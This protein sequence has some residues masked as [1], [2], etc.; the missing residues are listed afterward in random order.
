VRRLPLILLVPVLVVALG[1]CTR[2]AV[3]GGGEARQPA[4]TT[5]TTTTTATTMAASGGVLTRDG[6]VEGGKS[7]RLRLQVERVERYRAYALLRFA[8]TNPTQQAAFTLDGFATSRAGTDMGGFGV[9]D[10]VGRKIYYSLHERNEVGPAVGSRSPVNFKPGVRY[11]ASV[12]YPPIPP[13]VK[14][15]TVIPPGSFGPMTGVPVI[16]GG[17][18]PQLPSTES[19]DSPQPGQTVTL[20]ATL[21]GSNAWS[22]VDDLYSL[23]DGSAG[24]SN[25]SSGSSEVV[26][27]R[28]D[29]LFKFNSA[30]LTST[31]K[32]VI[33]QIADDMA[34]RAD[35]ARTVG[36]TGHTDGKGTDAFNQTLSVHRAQTVRDE[37][38]RRLATRGFRFQAAGK[39]ERQPIA[40]ETKADG[41]DNPQGR[42]RNRRVEIAYHVKT[43]ADAT[44]TT[45]SSPALGPNIGPPA[46]FRAD[47][48]PVVAQRTA[49]I[50]DSHNTSMRLDVHTFYRDGAYLVADFELTNLSDKWYNSS[51]DTF[52]TMDLIGAKFGGFTVV[53]PNKVRY[54]TVRKGPEGSV[55]YLSAGMGLLDPNVTVRKY[56]YYPA[57]PAG[58]TSVT[59]DAGPFGEISNVPIR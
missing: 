11:E 48:G 34:R 32:N 53:D 23:V 44:S 12:F 14:Q 39:G 58:V 57:P 10:P 36:V 45:R 51:F 31:A 18:Q 41:S 46:S 27:L 50:G 49:G 20:A 9:V 26:A 29:V 35:P 59:F 3:G 28:T 22:E 16:D 5:V 33:A 40:K 38:S 2:R 1:A 47:M 7:V 55:F 52:G 6:L 17:P 56:V 21:P 37:L 43:T 24:I 19:N 42:A 8:V 15:I 54:F 30:D 13:Q 25:R 4:S